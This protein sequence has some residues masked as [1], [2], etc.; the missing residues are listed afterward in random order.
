MSLAIASSI[1]DSFFPKVAAAHQR[2]LVVNYEG[3]VAALDRGDLGTPYPIVREMLAWIATTGDTRVIVVSGRTAREMS[4]L[5]GPGVPLEIWGAY[6]LERLCPDGRYIG[7]EL[8]DDMFDALTV[9]EEYLREA[10]IG[11]QLEIRP[12]AV[13]VCWE[14]SQQPDIRSLRTEVHR[15]L[16]LLAAASG[17]RVFAG[18]G[19]SEIRLPAAKPE[20]AAVALLAEIEADA[21]IAYLGAAPCDE[22]AFRILNGSGLTAIVRSHCEHTT[23]QLWLRPPDDLVGFLR[24]WIH[25]VSVQA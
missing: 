6:G 22:S 25:A 4:G 18:E 7:S 19:W 16:S 5:L 15:L 11:S 8:D 3:T 20:D 12:D 10:G 2:I 9:A 1:C 24:N 21:A 14:G 23:A 13:M 17:L